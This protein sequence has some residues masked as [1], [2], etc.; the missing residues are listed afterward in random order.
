MSYTYVPNGRFPIS[1]KINFTGVFFAVIFWTSFGLLIFY[2][3]DKTKFNNFIYGT[4]KEITKFFIDDIPNFFEFIANIISKWFVNTINKID[5]WIKNGFKNGFKNEVGHSHFHT[6]G[7]YSESKGYYGGFSKKQGHSHRH[8]HING[9]ESH[10]HK[11][12]KVDF[13]DVSYYKQEPT[14]AEE[15]I[16]KKKKQKEN[17]SIKEF[18]DYVNST[19]FH[20]LI[21]YLQIIITLFDKRPLL[22]NQIL[23]FLYL[24]TYFI[25]NMLYFMFTNTNNII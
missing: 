8:I 9:Q 4:G 12:N 1:K 25:G 23:L 24:V 14:N 16:E 20:L 21:S 5:F 15:Y 11:E 13:E 2:L 6:H 22:F 18:K 7:G 17:N 19:S 10:G 3:V